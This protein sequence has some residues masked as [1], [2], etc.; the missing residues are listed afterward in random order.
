MRDDDGDW[1]AY[2]IELNLR[3]GGT[4]HPFLTLQFLTDGSYDG[5]SGRS[6]PRWPRRST[7]WPPTTSRTTGLMALTVDDVFDIVATRRLH[8]DAARQTGVVLHMISCVTECGR[9]GLTAVGDSAEQAWEL[10]EEAQPR[11]PGGGQ[12][13]R[14]RGPSSRDP[15]S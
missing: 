6:A 3:K 11:D 14:P 8:F 7:S 1:T 5:P 15:T 9:L 4:T 12:A 13:A 2:A 10:Y